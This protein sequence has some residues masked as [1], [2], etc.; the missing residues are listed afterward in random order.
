MIGEMD[1]WNRGFDEGVIQVNWYRFWGPYMTV[2]NSGGYLKEYNLKEL[3]RGL[4]DTGL[5]GDGPHAKFFDGAYAEDM[6]NTYALDFIERHKDE[7]F[8]LYYPSKI[9]HWPTM[10]TPDTPKTPKVE[11]AIAASNSFPYDDGGTH[12]MPGD[13]EW[14]DD[15][16]AYLDKLVGNVLNKLDELVLRE[17]TLVVFAS[18]NG[19][20]S[21]GAVSEGFQRLP[22]S[23]G[24][25]ME[26]AT[27]V[28]CVLSWPERYR[29]VPNTTG[30]WISPI[31]RRL[32]R[33]WLVSNRPKTSW[34]ARVFCRR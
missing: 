5:S 9:P 28:P 2:F 17:N 3:P 7:P 33:R 25:V 32:L 4:N 14:E 26:G 22:G 1:P 21:D 10:P 6:L 20:G 12:E 30:W 23:K 29:R 16:M 24:G 19:P 15:Q 34:T 8:F 18:D 11:Q 13:G 27:R 31:S